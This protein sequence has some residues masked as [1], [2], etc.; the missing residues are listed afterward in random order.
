MPRLTV[1]R[2][3]TAA[4]VALAA[5]RL[6]LPASFEVFDLKVVDLRHLV[7]GPIAPGDEVVI[8]GI[9]EQSLATLGRWPWPRTRVAELIDAIGAAKPAVIGMDVVFDHR[10]EALDAARIRQ[11][12]ASA[13][14]RPAS[15]V[16]AE[17]EGAGDRELARALREAGPIG[18]AYFFE[19]D[20]GIAPVTAAEMAGLPELSVRSVSGADIR[21]AEFLPEGRRVHRPLPPLAAAAGDGGHINF[22]PDDDGL[23]R[24]VPLV[25]RVGDRA[26]PS[27]G[28][29]LVRRYLSNVPATVEL[30]PFEVRRLVLG[31]R[32][33]PV[34]ALGQLTI[35]CLGPTRTVP[36]LSAA[37]V[38]AGRVPAERFRGRIVVVGFTAAGFDD[39]STPFSPV[40]PGVELQAT[41]IDNLLHDRALWRPWWAVPMEAMTIVLAGLIV[42]TMGT[43]LRG[44]GGGVAA[45][46]V[47]AA[48]LIVSQALFANAGLVIGAVRP[49]LGTF[50]CA[51]AAVAFQA[52]RAEREKR[53]I[54]DAFSLY[55]NPEVTELVADDPRQ[56]RLGGER[57]EITVLFSDIRGF[58]TISEQLE[59]E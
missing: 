44:A 3:T 47:V 21:T 23:F 7:R 50:G 39:V 32:L 26:Y 15:E 10:D 24:R 56:L 12:V 14:R 19:F 29:Q 2:L 37:D 57:C 25:V 58:S 22:L 55:L 16:I 18:L 28:L 48:Y 54:R 20:H 5:L 51:L 33:L 46:L 17:V 52:T 27:L 45:L 8:V 4:G 11:A 40:G 30:S 6:L 43:R 59:P 35:N 1:A 53:R 41:M 49:V 36:H 38:L 13:P 9:D 34:N 31:T 42:G